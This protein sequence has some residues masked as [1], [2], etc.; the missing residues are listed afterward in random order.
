MRDSVLTGEGVMISTGPALTIVSPLVTLAG[1][2]WLLMNEG[3]LF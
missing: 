3:E 1:V 2:L